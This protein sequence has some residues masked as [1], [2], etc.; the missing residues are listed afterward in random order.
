MECR[1]Q[2][3]LSGSRSHGKSS[4]RTGLPS[5]IGL[6]VF[7]LL[8]AC[9]TRP[10]PVTEHPYAFHELLPPGAAT[11]AQ[12]QAMS[13]DQAVAIANDA[14]RSSFP[15]RGG[16]DALSFQFKRSTTRHSGNYLVAETKYVRTV[17]RTYTTSTTS[18]TIGWQNVFRLTPI[19]RSDGYHVI[20]I[21]FRARSDG[22]WKQHSERIW[23]RNTPH[24][25]EDLAL[26]LLVLTAVDDHGRLPH[27]NRRPLQG[28]RSKLFEMGTMGPFLRMENASMRRVIHERH[29]RG[30][31]SLG[32]PEIK[33]FSHPNYL[34]FLADRLRREFGDQEERLFKLAILLSA[35]NRSHFHENYDRFR[36]VAEAAGVKAQ[37]LE[38][39]RNRTRNLDDPGFNAARTELFRTISASLE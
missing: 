23:T 10:P 36:G 1:I 6:F 33:D 28:S 38:D 12:L 27:V 5:I 17:E 34:F 31:Q 15:G 8:T 3:S 21:H 7:F 25:T 20:N 16:A 35:A 2:L 18:G 4:A 32:L 30:I 26:A 37:I 19:R 39:F 29:A 22:Q 13:V 24:S 9:A 14:F 11:T